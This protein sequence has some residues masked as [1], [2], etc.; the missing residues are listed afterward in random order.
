MVS[1][2]G[3]STDLSISRILLRCGETQQK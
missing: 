2:G 3:G 1:S